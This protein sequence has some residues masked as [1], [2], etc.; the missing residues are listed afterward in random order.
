VRATG[1]ISRGCGSADGWL[2]KL[3]ELMECYFKKEPRPRIRMKVGNAAPFSYG[4]CS[5]VQLLIVAKA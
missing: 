4:H 2:D 5:A 1:L 3:R